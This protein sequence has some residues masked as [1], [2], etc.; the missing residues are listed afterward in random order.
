MLQITKPIKVV[1]NQTHISLK[2]DLRDYLI[3]LNTHYGI[4]KTTKLFRPAATTLSPQRYS[5]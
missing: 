1:Q 2:N 3:W 4:S 5:M